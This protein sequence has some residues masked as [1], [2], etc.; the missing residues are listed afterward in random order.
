MLKRQVSH[1]V[2]Y[3]KKLTQ[4]SAAIQA[5]EQRR[6]AQLLAALLG[7]LFLLN[8][9]SNIVQLITVPDFGPTAQV[10]LGVSI[11]LLGAYSLSRTRYYRGAV[12]IIAILPPVVAFAS[13]S[14]NPDDIISLAYVAV[15]LMICSIFCSIWAL[16][17]LATVNMIS[18]FL[19]PRFIPELTFPE[20]L[21]GPLSF[22]FIMAALIVLAIHHRN[23]VEKDRQAELAA[24]EARF[25]QIADNISEVF[26]IT[27]PDRRT[28]LYLSPSFERI[29]GR[30]C[31]SIYQDPTSFLD[32]IHE[33][34]R[35]RVTAELETCLQTS[36]TLTEHELEY[37]IVRP[38][39]SL[40]WIL[41]K[42]FP[43]RNRFQKVYRLVGVASDITERKQLEAQ[44][45]EAQKMEAVG[46]LAGGI[47]HDFN[48]ILTVISGYSE[49][50]LRRQTQDKRYYVKDIEEIKKAAERASSLTRQLLAFSRRQILQSKVL[51]VNTVI[52]DMENML[53]RLIS[54]DIELITALA[55]D[56]GSIKAD[57]GQLEQVILNLAVNARDAMPQGGKLIIETSNVYLDQAYAGQYR[58]VKTGPYILLALSDNGRGMNEAATSHVFEPFFT[59]KEPGKG[60]G[61]GLATVHGIINQSEG[62]VRVYSQLGLGTSFKVYL[63]RVDEKPTGNEP[64]LTKFGAMM[65]TETILVV[66]DEPMV[67]TLIQHTLAKQGYTVLTSSNGAEALRTFEEHQGTIDL[68]LTD[69][70]MPGG[71]N[72]R[73]LAEQIVSRQPTL[74]VLHMSGYSN[75]AIT[76]HG[77]LNEQSRFLQKPFTPTILVAKVHEVLNLP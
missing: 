41:D 45:M 40:R 75:E 37:R 29:W 18:I 24:S 28:I 53:R 33:E 13:L 14:V 20:D 8:T 46:R 57:Q 48:N 5:L 12:F 23:Q 76:N 11:V 3:W 17:S 56:L 34:D 35:N 47:A 22:I 21:S 16:L 77:L 69:L 65:G 43:L 72:G 51:D 63:P 49:L 27:D 10:L 67:R 9:A 58:D 54:E 25:R 2:S 64:Q 44:F 19:L 60:T 7:S 38:D 4:P 26:W 15:G 39:G 59:T 32:A 71:I 61:L 74:K 52:R 42:A 62:H 66:E 50:L 1:F 36:S 30:T 31:Q 73:Q 70:V 6:E 68:L 55:E